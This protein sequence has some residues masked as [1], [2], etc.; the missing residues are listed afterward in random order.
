MFFLILAV[1]GLF[2]PGAEAGLVYM[3]SPK[4]AKL[5]E[6]RIWLDALVQVFFQLSTASAGVI[7]YSSKKPK[8]ESFISILYIVPI[9]L[10]VCGLL[11]GLIIFMYV[12]HFCFEKGI[13]I[14]ELPLRGLDLAY[15]I[16]PKAI[17]ILPWPN[18][19]LFI[20]CLVLILLGIDTMFG[21]L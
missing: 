19:W 10:I 11:S 15:N 17:G 4:W 2:L 12:G 21:F 13:D 1:R 8:N 20:F 18:L 16:L 9:G 6:P 14:H 5:K 3:F 7:N